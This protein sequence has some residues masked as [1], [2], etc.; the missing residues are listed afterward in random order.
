M[1]IDAKILNKILANRIQEHIKTIIHPDQVVFIPMMQGLCNIIKIMKISLSPWC[2][3]NWWLSC[4]RMRI[5]PFLSPCTKVKSKY[6]KE[7]HIKPETL[8]L[9]EE[10]EGKSLENMGIG[11][12]FLNRTTM[13]CAGRLRINK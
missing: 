7:L 2:W 4:R 5:D 1:S 3:H 10:K 9:I 11:E 8:K 6:I 12:T 13:A